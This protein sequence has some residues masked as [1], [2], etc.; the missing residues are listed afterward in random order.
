MESLMQ[1]WFG[2]DVTVHRGDVAN[3]LAMTFDFTTPGEVR[4]TM[5]KLVD[6]IIAGCGVTE[7]RATPATEE[8]FNVRDAEKLNPIQKDRFR[9]YVAKLLFVAKRVKPEILVA[10]SFLSTRVLLCDVDDLAKL[11]RVLGYLIRTRHRGIVLRIGEYMTV[12]AYIDAAYGV[13]TASGRSH[14]GCAI[15]LGGGGP[16]FVR[17]SKQKIVVK[18]STEAELVAMSD[19][20][21]Q[22]IWVR[23]FVIAQGYDVGPVVIHQDNMSCMALMKRGAPASERSRHID[24]RYFWVKE[25]VDGKEAIVRHLRTEKMYANVM[26]KPVQGKQFVSERDCLT[27]WYE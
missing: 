10:V 24:I 1:G 19:N 18:S 25:R 21:S 27:N 6:E 7:E 20:T 26:T 13:H 23:N 17:S 12:E 8:L 2:G 15:V 11:N 5:K 16:V 22:A 14:S 3:Y 4:V 9:S